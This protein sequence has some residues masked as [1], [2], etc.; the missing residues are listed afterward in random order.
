[1]LADVLNFVDVAT[2]PAATEPSGAQIA[3]I[4]EA[5]EFRRFIV[6][7][8]VRAH[9]QLSS[10]RPVFW[11]QRM[12]MC[13]FLRDGRGVA[14]VTIDTSNRHPAAMHLLDAGMTIRRFASR[15]LD[16]RLRRGLRRDVLWH[17]GLRQYC[18]DWYGMFGRHASRVGRIIGSN[19][20]RNEYQE[21]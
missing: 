7:H 19:T 13:S 15:A 21:G 11:I 12:D 14:A 8:R 16:V 10:L 1:A 3:R 17:C 4:Y 9:W 18:A 6:Q 5:H 20:P 2:L